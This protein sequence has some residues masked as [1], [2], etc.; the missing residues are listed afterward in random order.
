VAPT[1]LLP[2][3]VEQGV[4]VAGG[5]HREIAGKYF[6]IGHMGISAVEQDRHHL[7]KVIDA[8]RQALLAC[9]HQKASA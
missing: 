3:I 5:L 7:D 9:G 6:R 4:V 2:K 8:I 1:D